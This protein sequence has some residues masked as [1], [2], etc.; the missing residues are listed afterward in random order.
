MKRRG[1]TLIELLVAVAL[2]ASLMV[3]AASVFRT[4]MDGRQRL[5]GRSERIAALRRTFE[6]LSRDF[7]SATVPPDDS[8]LQFGLTPPAAGGAELLQ[9]AAVVG[10]P[11]L[12]GRAA[13]ETVLLQYVVAEDPRTGTPTLFRHE[14]AY[15]VPEGAA[16]GES[17]DTR[18]Q[19]LLPGATGATYLFYS[20]AQQT[21]VESWEGEVGL[22]AAVRVD[23]AVQDTAEGPPRQES[24]VFTLPASRYETDEATAA[25]TD[26]AGAAAGTGAGAGGAGGGN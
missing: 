21:W 16:P 25:E 20:A 14:T 2:G 19:P 23:L 26:A 10:E 13:T 5:A 17:P 15:P 18:S 1:F 7:H 11:L 4:A 24:W 22:P 9:F 6:I 12:A 3:L 8:G